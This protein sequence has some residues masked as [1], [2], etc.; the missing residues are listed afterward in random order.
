MLNP[1]LDSTP[2]WN[3]PYSG[4]VRLQ[5]GP[6]AGVGRVE[7]YCNGQWGAICYDSGFNDNAANTVCTQLGYTNADNTSATSQ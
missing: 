6:Y 3:N 1:S 4:M 5:N 7:V 2:I